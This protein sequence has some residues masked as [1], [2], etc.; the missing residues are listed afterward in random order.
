MNITTPFKTAHRRVPNGQQ[1]TADRMLAIEGLR[2][3]AMILVFWGHFE[4]MFRDF[5]VPGSMSDRFVSVF[6][7][8]GHQGVSFFFVI[9]GYFVYSK[10]MGYETDYA[11]FVKK[12]LCRV[13]PLY[14]FMLVL[15]L[16][17]SFVVPSESKLPSDAW[18][19]IIY[20]GK[21]AL[22]FQGF[23]GRPIMVVSWALTYLVLAYIGLPVIEIGRAHV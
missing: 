6:G 22:F 17:L 19:A 14:W 9:T 15:Y 11:A 12:R 20:F 16:A 18:Q 1:N 5:L 13:V 7:I 3:F 8:W 2:G 4:R 10:F 21:N 23:M